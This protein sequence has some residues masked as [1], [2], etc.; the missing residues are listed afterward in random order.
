MPWIAAGAVGSAVVGAVGSNLAA[1]QAASASKSAAALQQQTAAQSAARLQPFTD[2]GQSAAQQL[3]TL[4][5]NGFTAGQPNYLAMAAGAQPNANT[6]A[7][8]VNTPGYQFNLS[9]G[10]QATQNAAAA[11]GLGVSGAA[12]KGASTYATGLA[13]STYQNQFANQQQIFTNDLNL[14]TGQQANATNLYN[15]LS[16]TAT[17]GENAAATTGSQAV[18]AANAAGGDLS[19]AGQA[20]ASGILGGTNAATSAI[21][22]GVANYQQQNYLNLLQQAYGS[23][24]TTGG[25]TGLTPATQ[26]TLAAHSALTGYNS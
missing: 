10:L 12:L 8:V 23:P 24:G 4:N 21:N 19:A 1:G 15:R 22:T 3:Q 17:L 6:M 18:T 7:G 26:N 9:Q 11:R 14:N 2:V 16:G 5:T 25:Y 13:D 20:I